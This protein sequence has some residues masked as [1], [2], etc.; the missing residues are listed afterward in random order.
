MKKFNDAQNLK[1]N[2]LELFRNLPPEDIQALLEFR[3]TVII[4]KRIKK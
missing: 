3:T 1:T 2:F 4:E